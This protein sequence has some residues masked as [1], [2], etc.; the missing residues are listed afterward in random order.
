MLTSVFIGGDS[1]TSFNA[2]IVVAIIGSE[3]TV[4]ILLSQYLEIKIPP[5]RTLTVRDVPRGFETTF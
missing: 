2:P 5:S 4:R 3:G 1:L